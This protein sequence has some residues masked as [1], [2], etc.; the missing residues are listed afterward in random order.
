VNGHPEMV[1]FF[2]TSPDFRILMTQ[3][4]LL[5]ACFHSGRSPL[6][7]IIAMSDRSEKM[8]SEMLKLYERF[9]GHIYAKPKTL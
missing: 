2:E 6:E 7:C 9:P 3:D 8:N 5:F 1:K 4:P